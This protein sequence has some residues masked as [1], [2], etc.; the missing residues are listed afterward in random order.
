MQTLNFAPYRVNLTPFAGV[1]NNGQPHTVSLSVFNADDYFSATATL[2]LYLDANAA[3]LSGEVTKNTLIATPNPQVLENIQTQNNGDITGTV[4][5]TS[6]RQFTISGYVTKPYGKVTTTVWQNINFSSVQ[7]FDITSS[8]YVQNIAQDTTIASSSTQYGGA[9]T[10][11]TS[12]QQNWP[13]NLDLNI[14]VNS[15]GSETQTTTLRQENFADT[16]VQKGTVQT[17]SQ[18]M[19]NLVNSTDALDIA[20][21]FITGNSGQA[22][23]Q[24][25][26]IFG[27]GVCY[28]LTLAAANNALASITNGCN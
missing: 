15:N 14:V 24:Q 22:S 23:S 4:S 26:S 1:L 17:Q 2:L 9:A 19:D 7:A 5:V 13:L 11:T 21:G 25:Y 3:D 6:N 12:S 28:D 20:G 27:N 8:T 18:V 10:L 16:T